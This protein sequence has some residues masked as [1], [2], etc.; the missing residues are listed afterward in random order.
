LSKGLVAAAEKLLGIFMT[1]GMRLM[2]GSVII[3][4]VTAYMVRLGASSSWQ[5]Y[6]TVDECLADASELFQAPVRVSGTIEAGSLRVD[7]QRGAAEFVLEG[8]QGRLSVKCGGELP[9]DLAEEKQVV[10]EGRLE[11][12]SELVGN[13]VLTRCASKYS[14]ASSSTGA[15]RIEPGDAR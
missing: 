14:S 13:R 9:D 2:I 1:T 15:V 3:L 5:Y 11:N 6:L 8:E 7:R 12:S 10:V 4:S